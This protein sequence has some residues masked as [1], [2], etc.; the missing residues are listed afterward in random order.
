MKKHK[1][2]LTEI[3]NKNFSFLYFISLVVLH[4]SFKKLKQFYFLVCVGKGM[5]KINQEKFLN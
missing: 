5:K 1:F 4:R 2:S 3:G